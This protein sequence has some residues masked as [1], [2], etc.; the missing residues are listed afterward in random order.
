MTA[1]N[2]AVTVSPQSSGKRGKTAKKFTAFAGNLTMGISWYN[3]MNVMN[4]TMANVYMCHQKKGWQWTSISIHCVRWS[5]ERKYRSYF[6]L[7]VFFI[8]LVCFCIFLFCLDTTDSDITSMESPRRNWA[9]FSNQ[10]QDIAHSPRRSWSVFSKPYQDSVRHPNNAVEDSDNE[11]RQECARKKKVVIMSPTNWNGMFTIISQIFAGY[12][13]RQNFVN[14]IS[15]NC[16]QRAW[17]FFA[18]LSWEK[19]QQ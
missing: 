6:L 1:S 9:V 5:R 17:T 3:A 14:W 10:D 2:G 7:F 16:G 8:E 11:T 18:K 4:D 12:P 15:G 13:E 19:P